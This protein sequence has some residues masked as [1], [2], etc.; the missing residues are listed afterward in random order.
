MRLWK[1]YQIAFLMLS[2]Y[3]KIHALLQKCLQKDLWIWQHFI[4]LR[5]YCI[6]SWHKWEK[7]THCQT[8]TTSVVIDIKE[9]I[10]LPN[11]NYIYCEGSIKTKS[12]TWKRSFTFPT[13]RLLQVWGEMLMSAIIYTWHSRCTSDFLYACWYW[14]SHWSLAWSSGVLSRTPSQMWGRLYLPVFLLKVR[15][16]FDC[17]GKVLPLPTHYAK[18]VQGVG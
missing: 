8:R 10:W 9:Q 11:V 15:L 7:R 2:V 1:C 17:S 6:S 4:F 14:S 5:K 16:L 3:L 13:E 12:L 18:V